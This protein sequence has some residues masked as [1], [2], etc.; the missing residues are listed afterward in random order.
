MMISG[1]EYFL[2]DLTMLKAEADD[3]KKP[4]WL[5]RSGK[6]FR[7]KKVRSGASRDERK[8]AHKNQQLSRMRNRA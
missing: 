4:H 6:K 2:P 7:R 1:M 5:R 8:K 3:R